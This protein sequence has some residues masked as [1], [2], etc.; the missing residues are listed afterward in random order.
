[1]TREAEVAALNE[2]ADELLREDESEGALKKAQEALNLAKEIGDRKGE[3]EAIRFLI[4]ATRNEAST[5][6][7]KPTD[8]DQ[9]AEE[10]LERFRS[11][12]DRRGEATMLLVLAELNSDRRGHRRRDRA[13]VWATEALALFRELGDK[14]MECNTLLEL[15]NIHYKKKDSPEILRTAN[16]AL[17]VAKELGDRSLEALAIHSQALSYVVGPDKKIDIGLEKARQAADIFHALGQRRLEATTL[18]AIANWHLSM[19]KPKK[20]LPV[21]EESLK[22]LRELPNAH[23]REANSLF[24]MV[25]A[26]IAKR[27]TKQALRVAQEARTRFRDAGNL[28]GEVAA[29]QMQ[30]SA[31]MAEKRIDEAMD[32]AEEALAASREGKD[33]RMEFDLLLAASRLYMGEKRYEEARSR[34]VDAELIGRDLGEPKRRA[35]ALRQLG[36]VHLHAEDPDRALHAAE[37][38]RELSRKAES[39]R[40]EAMALTIMAS[41]RAAKGH[42]AEAIACAQE[43]AQLFRA[44]G[45]TRRE[46]YLWTML[47]ELH[48]NRAAGG[49]KG[50][51]VKVQ[52]PDAAASALEAA[53]RSLELR[54]AAGDK[55]SEAEALLRVATLSL[56]HGDRAEAERVGIEAVRLFR[57]A[58]DANGEVNAHVFLCQLHVAAH[59][60]YAKPKKVKSSSSPHLHK[61]MQAANEGFALAKKTGDKKLKAWCLY[62]RAQI[63][64]WNKGFDQSLRAVNEA[65][66]LFQASSCQ[67]GEACA[68][69]LSADLYIIFGNDAKA[70]ECAEQALALARTVKDVSAEKMA[71]SALER[72]EK[73][74]QEQ[75]ARG[76]AQQQFV[77]QVQEVTAAPTAQAAASIAAKPEVKGLDPVMAKSKLMRMVKDVIASED[78]LEVDSP[79]MEAGMDSLSSVQ[80]MTEVSKEFQL[81]LSPSL[82]FDFPTVRAMVDHLVEE[83]KAALESAY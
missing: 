16:E 24:P 29:L 66:N 63:L 69:A 6:N 3:A 57:K 49:Q 40:G 43:A 41:A 46:S 67:D 34:L 78:D 80:L 17:A 68:L 8:A 59:S 60:A 19:D 65:Q 27:Q 52:D 12:G 22:I 25:D 44:C 33:R 71:L 1:M 5:A 81:S 30:A 35:E 39:E 79:F 55:K 75:L 47:S 48:Q 62:W 72:L 15:S 82:I 42:E 28:E 10:E 50:S 83:S 21:A 23:V 14:V 38:A 45:D 73:R 70:Q 77:Q 11:Q 7:I 20:A 61:A 9:R 13:L 54:Q 2:Q 64:M 76:K 18:R 51:G 37:E 32:I 31:L 74:R 56:A 36:S 58:G 4:L 26:L 53:E